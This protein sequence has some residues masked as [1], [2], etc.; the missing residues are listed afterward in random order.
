MTTLP[1]DHPPHDAGGRFDGPVMREEHEAAHWEK[2]AD[3]IR[4]LLAGHRLFTTDESRRMQE[5]LDSATYWAMPY[6]ERWIL[7]FSSLLIE[8]GTLPEAALL[9]EEARLRAEG[10]DRVEGAP[11]GHHHHHDDHDHDHDHDHDEDHPYQED[12]DAAETV[13]SPLRLRGMA[14]RNLLLAKGILTPG[15]IREEIARMD[16]RGPHNGAALVVRAWT[17]PDF[18]RRLAEDAVAAAAEL[19]LDSAGTKLAALFNTAQRHHLVVCTLCSCYP[20]SILGRPP[21]WYKSRA[22]RARAVRD[23][24]GILAEFGTT[25]PEGT[26]LRVHDSNA[27]LRYLVVPARPAGT[28][29][30]DPAR[31]ATLVTR[32]SMI[33]VTPA[34]SP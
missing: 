26:E 16:A 25:L 1:Q 15:E 3:A 21:A 30:W 27:E 29:G 28:E 22:Y 34:A 32:D 18:A 23:P 33:G 17:D 10:L 7:A 5:Q 19:G 6:Y 2:E 8:K 31:L 4:M 11:A 20:R 14:V 12:H 24:R 13:L 9:A